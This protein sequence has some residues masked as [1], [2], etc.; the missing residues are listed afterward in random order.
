MDVKIP[1]KDFLT[2]YVNKVRENV[3]KRMN[4]LYGLSKHP[5]VKLDEKWH[6]FAAY[7]VFDKVPKLGCFNNVNCIPK[8]AETE[9]QKA[10]TNCYKEL[11]VVEVQQTRCKC[12]KDNCNSD[13]L[14]S[15]FRQHPEWLKMLSSHQDQ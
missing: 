14:N 3:D 12:M 2:I 10:I 7:C 1:S 9:L 11:N 6:N 8:G 13:G 5:L 15:F 4:Y